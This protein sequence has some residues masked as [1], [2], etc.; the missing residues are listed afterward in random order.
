MT[1][2]YQAFEREGRA[3][4]M[5]T[6]WFIY[7]TNKNNLYCV[8]NNLP[9]KLQRSDVRIGIHRQENGLH[10]HGKA[11]NNSHMLLQTWEQSYVALSSFVSKIEFDGKTMVINIQ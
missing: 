7:Y 9:T 8:Y 6:M 4:T 5:W 1:K 2:W 3:D 11:L 10:S